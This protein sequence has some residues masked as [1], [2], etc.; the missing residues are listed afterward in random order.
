MPL[1][2]AWLAWIVAVH[3]AA[4]T[5]SLPLI[6]LATLGPIVALATWARA[7]VT[8]VLKKPW[9]WPYRVTCGVLIGAGALGIA[10]GARAA[11]IDARHLANSLVAAVFLSMSI[12]GWR[13]LVKPTPARIAVIAPALF[14]G[15]VVF[16]IAG[17]ALDLDLYWTWLAPTWPLLAIGIA[18]VFGAISSLFAFTPEI[19]EAQQIA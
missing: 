7:P 6:F 12:L 8:G 11:V 18:S 16:A 2:I 15:L 4:L 5:F 19:P 14:A 13:A 3:A 17:G 1:F 9:R 10:S